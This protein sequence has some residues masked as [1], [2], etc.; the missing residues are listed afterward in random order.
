MLEHKILKAFLSK[1]T[2]DTYR[3]RLTQ[4]SDTM[5]PWFNTVDW[6]HS[7][8]TTDLSL[9]DLSDIHLNVFNP[10]ATHK[11]KELI[12]LTMDL[13]RGA[14]VNPEVVVALIEERHKQ[15]RVAGWAE[16][17]IKISQGADGKLTFDDIA[18]EISDFELYT[19]HKVQ[20]EPFVITAE[21]M[22]TINAEKNKWEFHLRA[23]REKVTGIGPGTFSLVAARPESGKSLF[24]VSACFHSNGFAA[25]G[26]KVFYLANEESV[27][28]TKMRA[29]CCYF[30][31]D[32]TYIIR[33][34]DKFRELVA[35][36]DAKFI[37]TGLVKFYHE[38]GM[39]Y[40]KIEELIIEHQPDI[41][42]ID[43]LDKLSCSG[44]LDPIAKYGLIYTTMRE[45]S[46]NYGIA[47]VGVSQASAEASGRKFFGYECLEHSK[48]RKAA[49]LDLII[50]IGKEE[51]D[52]DNFVRYI[53]L[54][55]NKIGNRQGD[56]L[57]YTIDVEKSR[58]DD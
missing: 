57:S 6:W 48:T 25:Q 29:I 31:V 28:R 18:K 24:M 14:E 12:S 23:L 5:K 19:P 54:A 49:E 36:F 41:L 32:E 46:E 13:I 8:N 47:I 53:K 37:D 52:D 38:T 56:S 51:L 45:N 39:N 3:T 4:I 21:D 17:L 33:N 26:A 27:A 55:K 2:Y 50:C 7:K 9:D 10:V 40:L 20:F 43:Q 11:Q 16:S 34:P 58:M 30:N 44:N 42:I 22:L 1:E 35:E 15:E